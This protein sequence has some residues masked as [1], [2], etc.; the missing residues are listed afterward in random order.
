VPVVVGVDWFV[1]GQHINVYVL[2]GDLDLGL[3]EAV[4]HGLGSAVCSALSV[5]PG[6]SEVR[7]VAEHAAEEGGE[8]GGVKQKPAKAAT[9]KT[10]QN[11]ND[12]KRWSVHYGRWC[13]WQQHSLSLCSST[14]PCLL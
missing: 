3:R 8:G 13:V 7:L 1:P 10:A 9:T 11:T 4:L 2:K 5:A 12:K 14:A 6:C